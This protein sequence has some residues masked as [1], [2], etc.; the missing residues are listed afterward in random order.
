MKSCVSPTGLDH[1]KNRETVYLDHCHQT[2]PEARGTEMTIRCP[3]CGTQLPVGSRLN[4]FGN[5]GSLGGWTLGSTN[6][7][8]GL[9]SPFPVKTKLDKVTQN[10]Q[11]LCTSSQEPIL[12]RGITSAYGQRCSRASSKSLCFFILSWFQNHTT[13]R[14][15][16]QQWEWVTSIDFKDAYFHIPIQEQSRTFQISC[17]GS[18]IP[19]QSTVFWSVHCTHG[20]H[21][22]SKG[23]ETDGHTHGYN[24]PPVLRRLVGESHI[25]PGLSPAYNWLVKATSH[26]VCL[27]H[28][29]DPVKICQVLGWLVNLEKSELEPKAGLRTCRLPVRA[30]GRSG[31]TYTGPLAEPSQ[32]NT[33]NTVTTGLSGPAV[34]V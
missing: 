7:E 22:S 24:N 10:Y 26:Q 29:L 18:D 25:P 17:P 6:V 33:R 28:T 4:P 8:G 23:V 11:L 14:T 16:L 32:Q 13:I 27:Q 12:V 31:P 1:S 30:H 5:L 21:C 34:Y 9:H 20:A 19:V 2:G 3:K 15:T